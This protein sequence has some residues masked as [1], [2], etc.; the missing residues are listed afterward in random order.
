M[1]TCSKCKQ[2]KSLDNFYNKP[3]RKG[4]AS[5]CKQCFNSYC[6]QRWIDKKKEAIEY[7]G[8]CCN[9]CGY[10]KHY[11][12]MQFHHIDPTTKDVGWNKLRLRSW[13]KI[14]LELDKCELLCAN[15]HAIEHSNY[16]SLSS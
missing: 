11:A 4:T 5:E 13:D 7:K 8:G 9:R 14:T 2:I 10:D 1:K 3:D 15:C 16:K 12:A 6:V